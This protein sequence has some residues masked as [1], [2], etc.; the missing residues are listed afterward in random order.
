M[1]IIATPTFADAKDG[2]PMPRLVFRV[3]RGIDPPEPE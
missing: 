1:L 3:L 2:P